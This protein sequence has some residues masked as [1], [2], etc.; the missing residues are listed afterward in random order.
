M[1]CLRPKSGASVSYFLALASTVCLCFSHSFVTACCAG[2][3]RPRQNEACTSP[4][5]ELVCVK[6]VNRQALRS[7]LNIYLVSYLI[8]KLETP[9]LLE[10]SATEI[11][12]P[13]PAWSWSCEHRDEMYAS[14]R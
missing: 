13:F 9:F 2:E 8:W 10:V 6:T 12:R 1:L 5:S 7:F 14:P 11:A 4:T 3:S